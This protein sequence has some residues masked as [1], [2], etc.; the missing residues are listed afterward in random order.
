M[1]PG[2]LDGLTHL[3][4][5]G[6]TGNELD[7]PIADICHPAAHFGEVPRLD[8][9]VC[10]RVDA[11]HETLR[12][13]Q[14]SVIWKRK[15]IFKNPFNSCC[16]N[17]RISPLAGVSSSGFPLAA[18]DR[19]VLRRGNAPEPT[20]ASCRE[21]TPTSLLLALLRACCSFRPLGYRSSVALPLGFWL[22][23]SAISYD[24]SLPPSEP[25]RLPSPT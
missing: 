11:F 25:L 5:R 12:Q 16:H 14:A 19:P 22:G 6:F 18:H 2:A 1:S 24:P 15:C 8:F 4:Q 23:R 10:R 21:H 17:R 9:R 7:S 3:A 20:R 13:K